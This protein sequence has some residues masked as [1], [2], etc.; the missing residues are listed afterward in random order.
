M[1]NNSPDAAHRRKGIFL[2][3][4]PLIL[5]P[6]LFLLIYNS[7]PVSAE[8]SQPVNGM[9]LEMPK[10]ILAQKQESKSEAYVKEIEES[11]ENE[12]WG[13]PD[14]LV[15]QP[16]SKSLAGSGFE[17]D[18]FGFSTVSDLRGSAGI[19]RNVRTDRNADANPEAEMIRQ[20]REL[21]GLLN[22]QAAVENQFAYASGTSMPLT[23]DSE[24]RKLQDL[25]GSMESKPL[26]PDPEMQQLEHLIDKLLLLQNPQLINA[27]EPIQEQV[28]PMAMADLNEVQIDSD[29]LEEV[30]G[31][32]GLEEKEAPLVT[33]RKVFRK[34]IAASVAKSQE[35]FP[36]E[37]IEIQ[38]NQDLHLE[39]GM[40]PAGT[41][42]FAQ[43]SI[44]GS[45]L[46]L[47]VSG[48]LQSNTLIPVA[49]KGYGLDGIPG[50]ELGDVKGASQWLKETGNSA[51]GFN[52]N[53]YGMDWQ[54]QLATSGVEATRSLI[55]GKS[56]VKKL[57]IKSGH[58]FL[59][60]DSSHTNSQQL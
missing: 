51:Q 49:L 47:S 9:N 48:I 26:E 4:M 30:N 55:R 19:N 8:T 53:S 23:G 58:P 45:R 37:A 12:P 13:I 35:I 24:L 2:L 20:L 50:I 39:S 32:F 3:I 11:E 14:F 6:I 60:I 41:V 46:Q 10:P 40:V 54:S 59:L 36:G 52:I 5:L 22:Q 57:S 18:Q 56:K 29:S 27:Q 15:N 25:M 43:T 44:T 33:G 31:F 21:E 42:L 16:E 38:L 1:M 7:E 34:T 28:I 17:K